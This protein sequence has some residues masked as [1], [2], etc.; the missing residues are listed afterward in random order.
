MLINFLT[1]LRWTLMISR[2]RVYTML[3]YSALLFPWDV[4]N[5]KM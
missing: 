2:C 5:M 3:M 4:G 1:V